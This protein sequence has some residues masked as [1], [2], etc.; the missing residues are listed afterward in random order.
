[1][2]INFITIFS[3][4]VVIYVSYKIGV[5]NG[6]NTK[7]GFTG[8]TIET[9]DYDNKEKLRYS[10]ESGNTLEETVGKI[11]TLA[12]E[13]AILKWNYNLLKEELI[14]KI[15]KLLKEYESTT[16]RTEEII[17]SLSNDEL[18][19]FYNRPSIKTHPIDSN[20]PSVLIIVFLREPIKNILSYNQ[21]RL[22]ANYLHY[23]NNLNDEELKALVIQNKFIKIKLP[24]NM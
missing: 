4:I 12:K 3:C 9:I 21:L 6:E 24:E 5:A 18:A 7:F 11:E 14:I 8:E 17:K 23:V 22:L 16:I 19:S 13:N 10:F 2:D 15:T 1:M 20:H